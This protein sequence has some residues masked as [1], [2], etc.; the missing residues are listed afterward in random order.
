MIMKN[1]HIIIFFTCILLNACVRNWSSKD[2]VHP[3]IGKTVI[4]QRPVYL[5]YDHHPLHHTHYFIS[6]G[7]VE[8]SEIDLIG[9]LKKGTPLKILAFKYHPH[10][11]A[12]YM[13]ITG[14]LKHPYT[15]KEIKFEY[16]WQKLKTTQ[17]GFVIE[18]IGIAP[19]ETKN[20]PIFRE[21]K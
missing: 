18:G 14:F 15:G 9:K 8:S 20:T 21:I 12:T 11:D 6:E 7:I 13:L 2:V 5:L 1:F 4:L 16:D 19:W 3:I 17:D 10:T